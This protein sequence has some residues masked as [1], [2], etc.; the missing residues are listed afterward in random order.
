MVISVVVVVV[1]SIEVG[2][3]VNVDWDCDVDCFDVVVV[4]EVVVVVLVVVIGVNL[5]LDDD[6]PREVVACCWITFEQK[7]VLN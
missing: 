3:C 5:I 2:D 6:F 1:N 4:V 7:L